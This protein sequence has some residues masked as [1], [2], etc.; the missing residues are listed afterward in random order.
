MCLCRRQVRECER[1]KSFMVFKYAIFPRCHTTLSKYQQRQRRATIAKRTHRCFC[2]ECSCECVSLSLCVNPMP[3]QGIGLN[4]YCS[5]IS[6]YQMN[7][8]RDL[9]IIVGFNSTL[10]GKMGM[11]VE[12]VKCLC[13]RARA[14]SSCC[15]SKELNAATTEIGL[16]RI[17]HI[18][19]IKYYIYT[20]HGCSSKDTHKHTHATSERE[21]EQGARSRLN[22]ITTF[23]KWALSVPFFEIVA[24]WKWKKQDIFDLERETALFLCHF[25]TGLRVFVATS[26]TKMYAKSEREPKRTKKEL[27]TE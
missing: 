7:V 8:C 1:E 2:N 11:I 9:K 21:R 25:A 27:E 24:R 5:S 14:C 18:V 6:L 19:D 3:S 23:E 16:T 15:V 12:C 22:R 20:E 4:I 17:K 26:A 10:N 13:A